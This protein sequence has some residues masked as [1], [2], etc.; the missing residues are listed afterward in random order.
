MAAK[1]KTYTARPLHKDEQPTVFAPLLTECLAILRRANAP[2]TVEQVRAQVTTGQAVSHA[3]RSLEAKGLAKGA[4]QQQP[5]AK[6]TAQP[7]PGKKAGKTAT[8]AAPAPV[9]ATPAPTATTEPAAPAP[10]KAQRIANRKTAKVATS[11]PATS[12]QAA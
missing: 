5:S 3:L 2:M 8:A 10:S 6:A 9:A 11:A 4:W 12:E 1:L 7:A